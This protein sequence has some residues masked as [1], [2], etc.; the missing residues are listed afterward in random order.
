LIETVLQAAGDLLTGRRSERALKLAGVAIVVAAVG[1]WLLR[2]LPLLRPGGIFAAPVD[3]D[4][5]AYFS[6]SALLADGHVPYRDFVLP[7]PPGLAYLL[8]PIALVAGPETGFAAAR[9]GMTIL[10]AASIFLVGRL[11]LRHLGPAAGVVAALVYATYPEAVL[12]EHGVFLEP[13]L[14]LALLA[15]AALWLSI[16]ETSEPRKLNLR[17]VGAGLLCG[18]AMAFKLWA[19]LVVVALLL[20][21]PARARV[22]RALQLV[23]GLALATL[24]LWG[25]MVALAPGR[26]FHQ[27]AYFQ[28]ARPPDGIVSRHARLESIFFRDDGISTA[29]Q[30]RHFAATILALIGLAFV[31]SSRTRGRLE[32]F[33]GLWFVMAV[34]SFV[35]SRPYY[36]M[37]NSFLAPSAALLAGVAAAGLLGVAS[38]VRAA[39]A[40]A[41]VATA[42]ALIAPLVRLPQ[43]IDEGEKREFTVAATGDLIRARIP[44]D[45]C[46]I[47]FQ[48]AQLLAADRLPTVGR[49]R[50]FAVDPYVSMLLEQMDRTS[51]KYDSSLDAFRAQPPT[52][53]VTK[54]LRG[55]DFVVPGGFPGNVVLTPAQR[56]L[57]ESAYEP[58]EGA[59][60][61]WRRRI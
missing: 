59:P 52:T 27:V 41:A 15:A 31:A 14:N 49:G 33:A 46:L 38:R 11:A 51:L 19:L 30:S 29:I 10:G 26:F 53:S 56:R 25:P 60:A 6:A 9:I 23:G 44:E 48:P 32:R 1:G 54:A 2:L 28:A 57:L 3:F 55:C 35:F 21:L 36:E 22:A 58:L 42:A 7:S 17:A 34:A 40:I 16:P 61:L 18:L 39:P 12:Q 5:G 13:A 4:E 24:V 45:A 50:E 20:A 43:T 37:Y 47:A 8:A